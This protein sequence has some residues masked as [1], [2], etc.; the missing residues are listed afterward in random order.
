MSDVL[1][2]ARSK[3]ET[4]LV[5]IDEE[6]KQ[7]ERALSHLIGLDGGS[8]R[9]PS[10]KPSGRRSGA[11]RGKRKKQ[12]PK[13]QRR[14]EVLTAIAE[15]PGT[16]S[17]KVADKLDISPSQVSSVAKGLLKDKLVTKKGPAYT[18]KPEAKAKKTDPAAA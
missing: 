4:A 9:K 3:V 8:P 13:G 12:A 11:P 6:R 5:S 18:A 17:A 1:S 14:A 2:E 15:D 16:T 10:R 7:L